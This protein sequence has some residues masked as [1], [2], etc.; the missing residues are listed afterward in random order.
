MKKDGRY[1][2]ALPPAV[3]PFGLKRVDEVLAHRS[4]HLDRV[5]AMDSTIAVFIFTLGL[6]EI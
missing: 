1:F 6:T 3:G 5:A 2:D 4:I